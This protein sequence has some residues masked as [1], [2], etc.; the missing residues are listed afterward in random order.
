M[1]EVSNSRNSSGVITESNAIARFV[2][3]LRADTELLG[4]TLLESAQVDS[5]MD[6]SAHNIELPAT[7]WLYPVLGES[8]PS[9]LLM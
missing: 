8:I 2:A 1:L 6:Y 4:A 9:D 5:W 7:M 3:K